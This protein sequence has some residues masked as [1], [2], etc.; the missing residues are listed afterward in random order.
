MCNIEVS[1]NL[2][3]KDSDSLLY[4]SQKTNTIY[5][6]M[7]KL[8]SCA[9]VSFCLTLWFSVTEPVLS[10]LQQATSWRKIKVRPASAYTKAFPKQGCPIISHQSCTH[11][12][13]FC[14]TYA[15]IPL[16]LMNTPKPSPNFNLSDKWET[17]CPFYFYLFFYFI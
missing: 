12:H 13:T 11:T 6:W 1:C 3:E 17:F 15:Y 4:D 5:F 10:N 7:F 16:T 8:I 9:R 2:C 14:Y